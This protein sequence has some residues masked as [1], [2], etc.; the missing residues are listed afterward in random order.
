MDALQMAFGLIARSAPA[1]DRII[2][3]RP[4]GPGYW[5]GST[6]GRAMTVA[7]ASGEQC[8]DPAGHSAR[9]VGGRS[10]LYSAFFRPLPAAS[11]VVGV[12]W[13][14]QT[15]SR[16]RLVAGA[17]DPAR[18]LL[19]T[20]RRNRWTGLHLRTRQAGGHLQLRVQAQGRPGRLPHRGTRDRAADTG[21]RFLS[22]V[23]ELRDRYRGPQSAS[24]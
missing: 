1:E 24:H 23:G 20:P 11:V 2:V 10:L 7:E 12:A 16:T 5:S 17:Q 9:R 6:A 8:G 3:V 13:I 14:D 4:R 22:P 21:H 19:G 18:S 15:L